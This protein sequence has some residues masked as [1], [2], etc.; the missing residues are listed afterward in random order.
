MDQKPR[1]ESRWTHRS[2]WLWCGVVIGGVVA[3]PVLI[4]GM[5][6]RG[7]HAQGPQP[8]NSP[9]LVAY[10]A[11]G[12]NG[13]GDAYRLYFQ[14]SPSQ[15]L[16]VPTFAPPEEPTS[17][18]QATKTPVATVTKTPIATATKAKPTTPSPT[19]QGYGKPNR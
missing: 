9:Q 15:N 2:L 3:M 16:L 1:Q 12:Y 10:K 4:Q 5:N 19:P 7:V 14:A 6:I 17:V 11:P 13:P 8:S 18:P